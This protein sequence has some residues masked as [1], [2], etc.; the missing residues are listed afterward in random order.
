MDVSL[1]GEFTIST[2]DSQIE[3]GIIDRS[4]NTTSVGTILPHQFATRPTLDRTIGTLGSNVELS[5]GFTT[6][7]I[8]YGTNNVG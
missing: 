2:A 6:D 7:Y 3:A 4:K 1:A 5:L 8:S